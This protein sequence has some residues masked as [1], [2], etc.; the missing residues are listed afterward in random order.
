[1]LCL[2]TSDGK[3]GRKVMKNVWLLAGKLER[4]YKIELR[5]YRKREDINA[6]I[7]QIKRET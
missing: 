4:E 7:W 3:H 5:G 2:E 6:K 1:M